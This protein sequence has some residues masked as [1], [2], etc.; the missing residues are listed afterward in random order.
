[1]GFTTQPMPDRERYLLLT[2]LGPVFWLQ[3]KYVRRVTPRMPEPPGSRSGVCGSGPLVRVLVLGD[4]AAAGVGAESQ[5]EA[6]CGQLTQRLGLHHTIAWRLM[7]MNGLD[8]PGLVEMLERSPCE[9]FDV[10]V[11]SMGANDVTSL[12]SPREWLAWQDRLAKLVEQR[13]SPELLV[14]SA[15]PPMHAFT[16]IPQPLRWFAGRWAQE[17][18][19]LLSTVLAG[20]E[21]Q[22]TMHWHPK[23]APEQGLAMDGYHPSAQGYALW[24]QGLSEHIF[25]SSSCCSAQ[26]ASQ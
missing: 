3:A 9:R 12:L 13:F 7:A 15:V 17:M 1:M 10:V 11:V 22:R 24:A 18:N 20:K 19:R 21:S 26:T 16:A 8:S 25:L 23:M 5:D 4:S 6:L 2:L 14:H